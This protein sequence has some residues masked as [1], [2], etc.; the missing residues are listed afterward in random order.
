M[1]SWF[2]IWDINPKPGKIKIYTSGWPKNQKICWN[3]IGFPFPSG[4]KNIVLKFI[5]KRIIVIPLAKTGI[6][7]IN[8]IDVIIIAQE[9]KLIVI[10]LKYLDLKNNKVIIK[11]IDLIIDDIPLICNEKITKLIE[12]LFWVIRGG[13]KVHPVLILFIIIILINIILRDGIKSQNLKLFI[14]G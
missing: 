13:Y 3:I 10:I 2:I 14:R 12:I 7:R 8:K 1:V 9:N 4:L 6:E 5:S 11:F